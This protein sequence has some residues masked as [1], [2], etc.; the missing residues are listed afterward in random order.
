[1]TDGSQSA[2]LTREASPTLVRTFLFADIR[3]YT[4]FTQ[5]FGDEAAARLA[6]KFGAVARECLTAR[7]G[8]V[9]GLQGDEAVAV[10]GSARQA[11]RAAIELQARFD[12]ESSLDPSLP[13]LVGVG[14]DAG[15]AV[16]VADGYIG[17][18]L[19][20]AARLCKLAGPREVLASE[21]VVHI[22][23]KL[24]G[25][26]YTE[27]GFAQLKGF[28]DPVRIIHVVAEDD[29]RVG[30]APAPQ[31][32]TVSGDSTLPIG[33]FLGALPSSL[34]V[35]RESE[36][37]RL[38]DAVDAVASGH[39]RLVHLSGEPGVGKTRLAQEVML[40]A[41]N[42]NFLIATGRCYELHQSVPF[43]PFL[44]ALATAYSACPPSV[45]AVLPRRWPHVAR[46]LPDLNLELAPSGSNAQEEQQRL[47]RAVTGF[48]Q[49]IAAEV[50]VALLL[51]DLHS[52]DGASLELLQHLARHTRADRILLLGTYRDVEV[53]RGHPLEA[54]L[55]DLSREELVERIAVRR[56]EETATSE[57][58]G[59]TLGERDV[60]GQLAGLIYQRT[61]G[62]PFFVQQLLRFLVER[63]D[64][65]QEK[66]R[67]AQRAL[68]TIEVPESVRSVIGQ[69]LA[70]LREVTQEILQD[71][72]VL[73]Q[74]FR[75]EALSQL[76]GRSDE[77]LEPA[78]EEAGSTGL[79]REAGTDTWAFDHTLTQQ[80]L[81]TELPGRRKRRLHLAA[82]EALERTAEGSRARHNAELA[83][84]FLE[85]G[86]EERA[87]PYAIAAGDQARAVFANRE[88]ERQYT[89]ALEIA[90]ELG[91][92][93][94]EAE[95]LARRARVYLGMFQGKA[96]LQ[97]F[98]RLLE[99]SRK[100]GD[101]DQELAAM[102]GVAEA[103]YVVALDETEKDQASRCREM[104]EAAYALAQELNDQR[105][106]A[107]ALL[108]TRWFADFWP[109]YRQRALA[110]LEEALAISRRIGDEELI[111]DSELNTWR[112][113]RR[114]EAETISASLAIRL[115]ERGDLQR[116]NS[117]H[118]DMLWADFNW[119]NFRRAVGTGDAAIKL[120]DEI[121][122]PP[123]QYPTL[124]ALALLQ[125][126]RYDEA[127]YALQREV[128]DEAHPFGQ[129]MQ[130]LGLGM[131]ELELLAYE[132]AARVFEDL[133][134]RATRLQRTWM[135]N[136]GK[137]LRARCLVRTGTLDAAGLTQMRQELEGVDEERASA[138][139]AEI[140][141]ALGK[142]DEALADA[143]QAAREAADH[144]WTPEVVA[145]MEVQ[146][147]ALLAMNRAA[148]AASIAE[149]GI[150]M[151][152]AMGALP[153][154][155][156]LQ[157]LKSRAHQ[158][159]NDR[160]S[161]GRALARA[162]EIV[163]ALAASI[164]DAARQQRFLA[165]V[166]VSSVIGGVP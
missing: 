105:A 56:L 120:A 21:A 24:D 164:P 136:W 127:W 117:L 16:P 40:S 17:A 128:T 113:R 100:R 41:R 163:R 68:E 166:E 149:E 82:A 32:P 66:G 73:G 2:E 62:N 109:E 46:L 80:A 94:R 132:Q 39:G 112:R 43:Y 108:G 64:V 3:G 70:R 123:V 38:L 155:W 115:R 138:V 34:L 8:Q 5:E 25:I 42:R 18:A 134:R 61:E 147:L 44:D 118:F 101:R 88:A 60:S 90:A 75:F 48:L 71:A 121:G 86:Q 81:Y 33:A 22:A 36:M 52:A 12:R 146:S 125:L 45:R 10:F 158:Q 28:A 23:R 93:E 84:H 91:N 96:A 53:N 31:A 130:T 29:G 49:A 50:P 150:Q 107:R 92:I 165:T 156:R 116:L 142:L 20:L 26:V 9:I 11:L 30:G 99:G 106:M 89:T 135:Q 69:R 153:L 14:L 129:A 154:V 27:R 139:M 160:E 1:V 83:W 140:L 87:L 145:A 58:I 65:Y 35:A 114:A 6:A 161:A 54:V 144:D 126:G 95:T 19:N 7:E 103:S 98:E 74:T 76:A 97:D 137:R 59:V 13:L 79:V 102:L 51:D 133:I 110:N 122:A 157:A 159:L 63:G 119:G 4:R 148:D 152:E 143:E 77:E 131:Y 162:A 141:L 15:E 85:A 151:A 104:Y 72:S 37:Q 111:I 55:R 57:L 78:L 67:W 47:F 124:Q